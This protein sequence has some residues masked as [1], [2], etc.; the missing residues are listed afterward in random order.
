MLTCRLTASISLEKVLEK[1]FPKG[2]D[3]VHESVGGEMFY[4]CF[5]ASAVY[6]RRVVI[7]MISQ[8][9]HTESFYYKWKVQLKLGSVMQNEEL[10]PSSCFTYRLNIQIEV[11]YWW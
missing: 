8:T 6:G 9:H 3:I 7:R 4:L 1:E 5:N 2:A 11:L 10:H